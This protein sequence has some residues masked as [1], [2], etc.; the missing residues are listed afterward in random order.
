MFHLR[1]RRAEEVA[2]GSGT[3]VSMGIISSVGVSSGSGVVSVVGVMGTNLEARTPM[4]VP[5]RIRAKVI[6]VFFNRGDPLC[7][8]SVD[9]A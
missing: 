4:N 2:V 5:S 6:K 7:G 3:G 1:S 8:G 9:G